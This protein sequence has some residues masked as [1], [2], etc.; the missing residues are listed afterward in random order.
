MTR[1]KFILKWLGAVVT[2]N[3]E[4]KDLMREDLDKVIDK[5]KEPETFNTPCVPYQLCPKCL[6]AKKIETM[7]TSL[8]QICDICD[9]NG[10]I[11]M[12]KN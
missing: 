10:I 1:E 12:A 7:G 9:G 8:Y 6:G 3:E 2:Y 11:P 5:F 4:T